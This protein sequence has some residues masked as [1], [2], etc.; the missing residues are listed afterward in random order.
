MCDFFAGLEIESCTF[1]I[2]AEFYHAVRRENANK[3]LR[4]LC[5]VIEIR[6]GKEFGAESVI[7]RIMVIPFDPLIGL[8]Q[9]KKES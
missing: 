3:H 8:K 2:C 9:M 5:S 4:P 7:F 6:S 1:L